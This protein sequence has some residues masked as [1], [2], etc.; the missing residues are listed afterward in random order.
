MIVRMAI[1]LMIASVGAS[2]GRLVGVE[3]A[4]VGSVMRRYVQ[5]EEALGMSS[6]RSGREV[7]PLAK[8]QLG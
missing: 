7:E 3:G 5:S 6:G 4:S 2:V 8:P 1:R